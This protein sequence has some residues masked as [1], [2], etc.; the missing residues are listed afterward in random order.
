MAAVVGFVAATVAVRELVELELVQKPRGWSE[1]VPLTMGQP[2]G[3]ER[4]C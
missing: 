2:F 3:H 4:Y 1:L